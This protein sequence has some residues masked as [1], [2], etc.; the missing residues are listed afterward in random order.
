[1][2]GNT[3]ESSRRYATRLRGVWFAARYGTPPSRRRLSQPPARARARQRAS[4]LCC[5]EARQVAGVEA[6]CRRGEEYVC[7]GKRRV[8]AQ[9][10]ARQM[11]FM[12]ADVCRRC[13]TRDSAH[14]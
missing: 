5:K 9:R 4:V 8:R 10:K 6:V 14:T 13:Y 2:L 12:R 7:V 11:C 3:I 1:V